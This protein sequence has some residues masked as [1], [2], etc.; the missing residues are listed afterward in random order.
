MNQIALTE[1]QKKIV[2]EILIRHFPS[3]KCYVFGSRATQKRLKPFSD[4]DI[5][6]ELQ[7]N[8]DK[9]LLLLAEEEFSSSDLPFKVDLID[10]KATSKEFLNK[11][12]PDLI[13]LNL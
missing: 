10:L 1:K 7:S 5:A 11:I 4:L 2:L 9:N 8:I 6:I 3:G 13:P 12:K